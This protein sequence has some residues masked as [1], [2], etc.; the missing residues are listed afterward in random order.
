MAS[1]KPG[2]TGYTRAGNE[3]ESTEWT[4]S[5]DLGGISEFSI[6][7]QHLNFTPNDDRYF[8]Q[9]ASFSNGN[10]SALNPQ[11]L[12]TQT[13]PP[14]LARKSSVSGHRQYHTDSRVLGR[15]FDS[16]N[17]FPP[18]LGASATEFSTVDPRYLIVRKHPRA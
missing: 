18:G 1:P 15:R 14:F 13:A 4:T 10:P 8:Q 6:S 7:P 5:H 2:P 17:R 3:G 11:D 12:I 16:N 9:Q